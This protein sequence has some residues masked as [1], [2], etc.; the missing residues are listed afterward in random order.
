MHRSF[1][2][3]A[4]N[5]AAAIMFAAADAGGAVA[6]APAADAVKKSIVPTKY[7]GKYKNGGSDALAEFIKTQCTGKD[8]FEFQAFFNLCRIND[9]PEE[10]V[11]VY[12][13]QVADK[14]HGAPGRARM[15]LRN[16]LATPARKTGK[17]KGLD[18]KEHDVVV[19]KPV[20]SGAAA[21]AKEDAAEKTKVEAD[22]KIAEAGK[23]GK[24]TK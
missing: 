5:I 7:A 12:E 8:G 1:I 13:Q 24:K 2:H 4:G 19:A 10:K 3:L 9:L 14:V 23:N 15:T 11:A 16:M 21:K 17:L 18:K 6:E 20:A 22:A